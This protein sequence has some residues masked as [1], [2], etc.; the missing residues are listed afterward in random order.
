[1]LIRPVE[2]TDLPAL[3]AAYA[4]F[5]LEQQQKFD[6]V[7]PTMDTEELDNFVLA[8]VRSLPTPSFRCWMAE[9]HGQRLLGFLGAAIETRAVSKPHRY[10]YVHWLWVDPSERGHGIGKGLSRVLMDWYA[11]EGVDALETHAIAGDV[12]WQG[13]GWTPIR[14]HLMAPRE[15]VAAWASESSIPSDAP[16]VATR[17]V[18]TE[19]PP[20]KIRRR[21]RRQ[22][23]N[24]QD[25]AR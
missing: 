24:G 7:Y 8:L 3:R 17:P 2:L 23:V 1:M 14:T 15:K 18:I 22:H 6:G 21:K 5:C 13:R 11:A 16:P 12:Q 25:H 4:G 19:R 10:G 9:G 20:P